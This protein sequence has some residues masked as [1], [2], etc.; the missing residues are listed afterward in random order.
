MTDHADCLFCRLVRGELPRHQVYENDDFLVLLTIAPVNP[1][2]VMVVPKAHIANFY[3]VDDALYV[4]LMLL[5]KRMAQ[6]I[7]GALQPLQVVLETSGIDNRHVHVHV[8][9][10]NGP[11]DVI[12]EE[13]TAR[14]ETNRPSADDLAAIQQ[15]LTAHM[16]SRPED[17]AL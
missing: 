15:L 7:K 1:G 3:E 14:L 17:A 5:V 16:A 13:T 6:V 10:V 4:P 9:P 8:I 12:A 2:Y 11:Y